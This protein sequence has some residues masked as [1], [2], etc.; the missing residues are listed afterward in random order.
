M[1]RDEWKKVTHRLAGTN[2]K[3]FKPKE[4]I[5]IQ[6][7]IETASADEGFWKGDIDPTTLEPTV[8]P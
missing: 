2:A 3:F 6:D 4:N 5:I 8:K 7:F 1:K